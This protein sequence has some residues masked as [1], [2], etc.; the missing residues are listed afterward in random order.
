MTEGGQSRSTRLGRVVRPTVGRLLLAMY[1]TRFDGTDNVPAGG[2]V[3][4][5]NHVS[6]LDPVLLWSGS[7]RPVAFMAKREIFH[8]VMGWAL[9]RLWAFPVDRTGADRAAIATATRVAEEGGLV[10]IF[11]E[12]TRRPDGALGE[13]YG[14]AAFVALRA[15]VPVVPV[16]IVGT[17]AAWPIGRR[18]PRL[19]RVTIRYGEPV[20]PGSFEGPRKERVGA[21]TGEIMRR[22]DEELGVARRLH[23]AR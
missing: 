7:S 4:A 6:Y 8:G 11:P 22:I 1:R 21:M 14:G 12:G 13:A 15:G 19:G 16:A 17:G 2:A 23:D 5:G 9:P 18:L 3:L 20:H 10:G